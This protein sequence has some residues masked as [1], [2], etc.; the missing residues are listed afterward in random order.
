MGNEHIRKQLNVL[1]VI[2]ARGGSKGLPGKNI[3]DLNG[4]PLIAWSIEECKKSKYITD[5]IVSTDDA[6]IAEVAKTW[7]GEVPFLRPAELAEDSTPHLPVM[8][9]ATDFMEQQKGTQYD[10]VV[11]IQPTSP[12][13]KAEYIDNLIDVIIEEGATS[14]VTVFEIEGKWHPIKMKRMKGNFIEDYCVPEAKSGVRRQEY[15]R[16]YK[17]SSD[18]FITDREFLMEKDEIY[19]DKMV[20]Y[21]VSSERAIDIDTI[22]DWKRAEEIAKRILN[23]EI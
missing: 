10:Y 4:K 23:G 19:T 21:I 5:L 13:R 18:V 12:F 20:G 3:K 2:T 15:E 17:R 1:A 7:G 8:Q 14:G 16:V 22:E 9:H 11:I 6:E